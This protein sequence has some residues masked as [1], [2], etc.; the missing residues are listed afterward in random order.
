MARGPK[1]E[2]RPDDPAS[3]A[4]VALRVMLGE[5]EENVDGNVTVKDSAAVSLG[6]R[7]GLR[8]GVARASALSADQRSEIAKKA[9]LAR[10]KKQ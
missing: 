8:G 7:G 2:K 9:A 4:V 6:R 1:G 3:A 10:W 5:V